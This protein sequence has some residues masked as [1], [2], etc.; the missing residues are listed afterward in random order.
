MV[1]VTKLQD[2]C[3]LREIVSHLKLHALTLQE[4]EKEISERALKS[5]IK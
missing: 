1:N 5:D 4:H 2:K 3:L